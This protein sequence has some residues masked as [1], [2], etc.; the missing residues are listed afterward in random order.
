MLPISFPKHPGESQW[1]PLFHLHA[2]SFDS[3]NGYHGFRNKHAHSI[4]F[5]ENGIILYSGSVGGLYLPTCT[6]REF[7]NHFI[8]EL[9]SN[10]HHTFC[11]VWET[12]CSGE[13]SITRFGSPSHIS[14]RKR[15]YYAM[16]M[17]KSYA[18]RETC[19]KNHGHTMY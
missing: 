8:P 11:R 3:E 12:F 7:E 18:V 10:W 9:L 19:V 14:D 1:M 13:S 16:L 2:Y 4:I 5:H 6:G 17:T 15:Q